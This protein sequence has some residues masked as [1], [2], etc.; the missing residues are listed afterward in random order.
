MDD[1]GGGSYAGEVTIGIS[2]NNGKPHLFAYNDGRDRVFLT[3]FGDDYDY[4][5]ATTTEYGTYKYEDFV[6]QR[7]INARL[8]ARQAR[9]EHGQTPNIRRSRR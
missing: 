7:V 2:P 3:N 1:G 6:T 4:I 5:P 9:F 8:R